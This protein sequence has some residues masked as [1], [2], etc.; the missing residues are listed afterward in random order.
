[1]KT[2]KIQELLNELIMKTKE[3]KE[4]IYKELKK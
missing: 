2:D 1:M 4:I 3:V